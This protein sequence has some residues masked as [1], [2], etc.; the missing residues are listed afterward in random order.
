VTVRTRKPRGEKDGEVRL[1]VEVR[2]RLFGT[3]RAEVLVPVEG[4]AVRWAPRLVFPGLGPGVRLNRRE[5]LPLRASIL[6]H[7]G[8]T[9]AKGPARARSSPLG[10]VSSIVG[11]VAP[12]SGAAARLP[13]LLAWA[14]VAACVALLV[15]VAVIVFQLH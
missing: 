2:T 15:C 13:A 11:R 10:D 12:A 3:V 9:L 5:D 8:R 6:S 14:N 1:P 4:N 7:D